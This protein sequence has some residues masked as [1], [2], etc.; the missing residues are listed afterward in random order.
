MNP[1][2]SENLPGVVRVTLPAGWGDV[3]RR[4]AEREAK[5]GSGRPTLQV[6][7]D[8]IAQEAER[9]GITDLPPVPWEE[10]SSAG[11]E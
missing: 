11:D 4:I 10:A 6:L 9:L 5:P 1:L 7:I 3:L 2:S 8:L